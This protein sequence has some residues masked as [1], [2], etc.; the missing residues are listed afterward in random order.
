MRVTAA[1]KRVVSILGT[2]VTNG[3]TVTAN[4]DTIGFDF[5]SIDLV[6][7]TSN[8][9]SNKPSTLKLSESDDTV[10][11]NFADITA[12]VGGGTGGFT[13]P[14]ADTSNANVYVFNVDCRGRKRYLKLTAT[15]VTTQAAVMD[16]RLSCAE[17]APNTTSE[18]GTGVLAV[19]EG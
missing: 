7:G 10:V 4:I 12:F 11:T 6:L 17:E 18:F 13:I 16:A 1:A 3:A 14:N 5:A 15:P 9:V 19:V 2:G 8:T